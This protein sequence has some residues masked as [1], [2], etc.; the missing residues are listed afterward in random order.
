MREKNVLFFKKLFKPPSGATLLLLIYLLSGCT[1]PGTTS[2]Q[3]PIQLYDLHGKLICQIHGQDQQLNCLGQ[4]TTQSP[5]ASHF[6][7]YALNELASDLHVSVANLPTSGL[8][9]TTTLDL[10]LQKQVLQN[11]KRYIS[12]MAKTHKMSDA[13]VVILDYH[14]GAIR[15][16]FGNLDNVVTDTR[17]NVATQNVRQVGSVFKPFVYATAFDL[18]I[19]PGEVVYDGKFSVGK[20]A[21]TPNNYDGTYHGYMSYRSA[22]QKN[23]NI[24]ALKL[25]LKIGG[26]DT[27]A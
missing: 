7:T 16:L 23:L 9:V 4:N 10:D 5:F 15:A 14:N 12:T 25:Y 27:L 11:T 20:P 18:G 22:L 3:G 24:P 6:I 26:F 17:A 13:A 2:T 19:S 21:Y 8:K 1:N